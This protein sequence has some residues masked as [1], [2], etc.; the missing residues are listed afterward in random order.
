[1]DN[2]YIYERLLEI[3]KEP[4]HIDIRKKVNDLATNIRLSNQV[5]PAFV[6]TKKALLVGINYIGTP[7]A[8]NGCINDTISMKERLIASYGFRG[9][10]IEIINDTTE[11]KPTKQNIITGLNSLIANS[12]P[13]DTLVFL[14]SGHGSNLKDRNKDEWDGFD[15][16]I[17]PLDFNYIV[18]D[19][20]LGI[21]K[22]VKKGVNMLM[23]FDCCNSGS[24]V[25]LKYQYLDTMKRTSLTIN[26]VSK[27]LQG[28]IVCISGCQDNQTSADAYIQDKYCGAMTWSLLECTKLNKKPTWNVLI[29]N[30]RNCLRGKYSQIVQISSDKRIDFNAPIFL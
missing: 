27:E 10:D 29:S 2:Q 17:V 25:D 15:E 16:L 3:L 13:G 26:N 14:Y 11:K 30:M 8:L 24:I 7:Y 28:N 4:N 23:I 12:K 9:E 18:D 20:I 22:N 5:V 6:A 1:M 21:V 19:E